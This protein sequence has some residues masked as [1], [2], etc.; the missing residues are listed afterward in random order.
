MHELLNKYL[1]E[2][3]SEDDFNA[4]LGKLSEDDRKKFDEDL[5]KPEVQSQL[6]DAGKKAL[7]IVSAL[8]KEKKRIGEP[9]PKGDYASTLRKEN[10]ETA[11]D[12]F[13]K[14]FTVPPEER[15]H[16]RDV[17]QTNDSGEVGV[18]KILS[19]IKKIY[20]VEHSDELLS[21]RDHYEAI[22][23]G[24]EE[25]NADMSGAPDRKSVV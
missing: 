16:Y 10:L 18:D 22:R 15:Q 4:E 25:F 21:V 11:F 1:K 5:A 2:E 23:S 19:S 6:K 9:N 13:F 20:A 3:I 24:A 7:D 14:D 17:F 12:S 8:R